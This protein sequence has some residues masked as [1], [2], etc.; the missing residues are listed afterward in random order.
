MRA[1]FGSKSITLWFSEREMRDYKP[2]L[3]WTDTA[4]SLYARVDNLYNYVYKYYVG[5][6]LYYK[7]QVDSIPS[8]GGWD[9]T[10][11]LKGDAA[12][13]V[14]S[15]PTK[16]QAIFLAEMGLKHLAIKHLNNERSD[17]IGW[18][19]VLSALIPPQLR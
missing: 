17:W 18:A 15:A 4:Q 7:P 5:D 14:L 12:A 1:D 16:D 2:I 6:R 11:W 13:Q 9:V 3:N 10:G 19:K 8:C